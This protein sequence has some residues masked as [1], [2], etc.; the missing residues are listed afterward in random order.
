MSEFTPRAK[1]FAPSCELL[2]LEVDLTLGRADPAGSSNSRTVLSGFREY[3]P[4]NLLSHGIVWTNLSGMRPQRVH[5]A[6]E[7]RV[8][9][10]R[11]EGVGAKG[12][13]SYEFRPVRGHS[14]PDDR[15]VLGDKASSDEGR[16]DV[17]ARRQIRIEHGAN[18]R[19]E[20]RNDDIVFTRGS[21]HAKIASG[22]QNP[23][24]LARRGNRLGKVMI[25]LRHEYEID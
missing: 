15:M 2:G 21:L 19:K 14:F 11:Q 25:D 20:A 3:P 6:I 10:A 8:G 12:G 7:F 17:I 13:L 24:A 1:A 18:G 23:P 16:A 5:S 9:Q 22:T 4:I